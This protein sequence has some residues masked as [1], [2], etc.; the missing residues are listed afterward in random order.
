MIKA[1]FYKWIRQNDQV[2]AQLIGIFVVD[3]EFLINRKY[4]SI[5]T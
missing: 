3:C 2:L 4:N 1:P 5:V